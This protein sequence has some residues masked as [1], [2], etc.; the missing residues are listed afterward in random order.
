MTGARIPRR[1]LAVAFVVILLNAW[2]TW[3]VWESRGLRLIQDTASHGIG[4]IG[5]ET[6][7]EETTFVLENYLWGMRRV[8]S[9]FWLF[10]FDP[11]TGDPT[12]PPEFAGARV[13][14]SFNVSINET[15]I[16]LFYGDAP[17]R[18]PHVVTRSLQHL[19][20]GVGC[21][22]LQQGSHYRILDVEEQPNAARDHRAVG[23]HRGLLQIVN[24]CSNLIPGLS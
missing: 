8:S 1:A 15:R 10:P 23:D 13:R 18:A 5:N 9:W 24:Q 4:E 19:R 22:Q 3:L 17:L 6:H 21:S 11:T 16:Q 7:I 20:M 14:A 12:G 2:A